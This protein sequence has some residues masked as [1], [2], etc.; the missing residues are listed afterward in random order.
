MTHYRLKNSDDGK[1]RCGSEAKLEEE[2]IVRP[3]SETIIWDTYRVDTILQGSTYTC[4]SMGKCS[5]LGNANSPFFK[6]S[7]V[8]L[9][10]RAYSMQQRQ[11]QYKKQNK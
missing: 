2:L 11:R 5:A 4:Q 10:G 3:T 1:G 8:P 9:A 7:R 6:N